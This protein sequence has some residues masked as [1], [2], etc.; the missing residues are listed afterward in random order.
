M[1]DFDPQEDRDELD[2][3]NFDRPRGIL[4]EADR[5]YLCGESNIAEQSH[6]ERRARERI[7]ERITHAILDFDILL[8]QFEKRDADLIVTQGG[9]E[10]D[11]SLLTRTSHVIGFIFFLYCERNIAWFTEDI[12]AG[13]KRAFGRAGWMAD[14]ESDLDYELKEQID[15]IPNKHIKENLGSLSRERLRDFLLSG[16]IS[17]EEFSAEVQRRQDDDDE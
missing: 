3:Y 16:T 5:R 9:E 13:V 1:P 8:G 4:T 17:D 6:S 12:D 15:Q 7:R 11:L 14:V 10:P 2:P